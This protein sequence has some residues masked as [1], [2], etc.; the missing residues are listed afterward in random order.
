MKLKY[1]IGFILAFCMVFLFAG[2]ASADASSTGFNGSTSVIDSTYLENETIITPMAEVPEKYPGT[3][4]T[5]QAGDII[6]NPKSIST[7]LAGH[8]GIV[9]TDG[10]IYHVHPQGPY[11]I[12]ELNKYIGRFAKGDRFTIV[13]AYGG[14]G[15]AAA[16][17]AMNN[18]R[19]VKNY[20][21]NY[22]LDNIADS[23]C[24]KFVWQ[25]YYYGAGNEIANLY[26]TSYGY[27]LPSDIKKYNSEIGSFTKNY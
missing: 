4:I 8:V 14:G 5:V 20:T 25:A 19:K 9:G 7:F 2:L 21:F 10:R 6:F 27:V 12:D 1:S 3:N 23:Y 15:T 18:I 17:W 16:K 11:L 24:S 13:R 22:P 26:Q